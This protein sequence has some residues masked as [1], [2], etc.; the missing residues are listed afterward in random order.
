[1][2]R[3]AWTRE[4]PTEP[5]WYW[6]TKKLGY[7]GTIGWVSSARMILFLDGHFVSIGSLEGYRA[8]PISHPEEP[9]G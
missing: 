6:W 3:L 5:G 7:N 8:G 9:R 4:R 1:M 2:A